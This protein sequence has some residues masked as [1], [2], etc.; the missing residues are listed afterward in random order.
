MMKGAQELGG[1]LE[2]LIHRGEGFEMEGEMMQRLADQIVEGLLRSG[3]GA[4]KVTG[5]QL[6]GRSSEN[7][8]GDQPIRFRVSGGGR[9]RANGFDPSRH[10]PSWKNHGQNMDKR[11]V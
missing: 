2:V 4:R 8:P 5:A 3:L 7:R 1:T 9:E 11:R 6:G 10:M